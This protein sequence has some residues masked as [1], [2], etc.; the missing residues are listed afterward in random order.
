MAVSV[1]NVTMK[2]CDLKRDDLVGIHG[3]PYLVED[4]KIST[5]S[6]RGASTLYRF[7]FRNLVTKH[8]IDLTC[9]GDDA[10][11]TIA[12]EKRPVQF[13]YAQQGQ[14]TFMDVEDFSQFTL[15]AGEIEEQAPF[16]VENMEGIQA[17]VAD[18]RILTLELPAAVELKI[19]ACDP[20][21]KGASATSRSKPATLETGLV[22]QV[23]EYLTP[24]EGI[25]VDT[26]TRRFLQRA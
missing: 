22:V 26:R 9:K 4:L 19:A 23:P 5:P 11:E 10:F 13:L 3:L 1:G 6:A 16:L 15:N 20:A 17:L 18:G 8:K 14:Y 25:R 12:F 21:L 7:R 2:A 24:G